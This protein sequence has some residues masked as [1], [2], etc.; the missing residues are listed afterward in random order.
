[1]A[2]SLTR[3]GMQ[4]QDF[5]ELHKWTLLTSITALHTGLRS[6]LE[7]MTFSPSSQDM[8]QEF[9]KAAVLHAEKGYPSH[10]MKQIRV[11]VSVYGTLRLPPH[12]VSHRYAIVGQI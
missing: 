5:V 1:M 7:R 11:L 10:R 3:N 6:E 8:R 2:F 12:K 9:R 4:G